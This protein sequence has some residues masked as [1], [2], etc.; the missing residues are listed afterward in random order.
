MPE[1]AGDPAP[2][3]EAADPA[4]PPLLRLPLQPQP[5]LPMTLAADAPSLVAGMLK[6]A[7]AALSRIE[8]MQLEAHPS[9]SPQACM[10]EVPVRDGD[11]FD[12]LQVRIEQDAEAAQ[13]AAEPNWTLGF[14]LDPPNLGAV[15]GQ[16]RL[17]GAQVN[18]DLWAKNEAGAAAL[19]EQASVLSRLLEGSGLQLVQ[20]R[21]RRGTPLRHTGLG[22]TL[23][24]ARA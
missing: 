16:I 3:P 10:L 22:R 19:E 13:A 1:E 24:E 17:H 9:V 15:H 6:H 14:T 18:V 20:L 11:G 8:I 4:P 21:V 5:R 2:A 23:L 12:V 7:E